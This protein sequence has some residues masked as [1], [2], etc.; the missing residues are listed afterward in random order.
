M[1]ATPE[2]QLLRQELV[3]AKLLTEDGQEWNQVQWSAELGHLVATA[4]APM[5]LARAHALLQD[6]LQVVQQPC[7]VL[8]FHALKSLERVEAKDG[9]TVI[10]WKLVIG[11]RTEAACQLYQKVSALCHCALTQLIMTRV[12]MATMKRSPLAQQISQMIHA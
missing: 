11:M 7:L 12:R 1:G 2:G 4:E 8:R 6:I 10:P 9:G 5:T 3:K